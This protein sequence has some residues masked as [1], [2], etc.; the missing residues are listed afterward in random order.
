MINGIGCINNYMNCM[1]TARARPEHAE[2]FN[3]MDTDGSGGIS[4]GELD[5][6]VQQMANQR[7]EGIDTTNAVYTYDADGD[8]ELSQDEMNTFMKETMGPP[9][10]MGGAGPG[11][12][13]N[14]LFN[15]LDTDSSGG[16][17]EK[18]LDAFV[19]DMSSQ[20]GEGI[21]TTTDAFSTYDSDGNGELSQDEL[22]TFMKA[23]GMAPPPP[24]PHGGGGMMTG[25]SSDE[26]SS[27]SSADSIISAYDTNGDGVL[28]ADEL[29]TYLD[30]SGTASVNSLTQQALSAYMMNFENSQ[31]FNTENA[32]LNFAGFNGYSP[33]DL[34]A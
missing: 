18:E 1:Q 24:P 29:Q 9:P 33:V 16:V 14:G 10:H 5:T 31:S 12:D 4:Q 23:S 13:P 25:I 26:E 32:L 34:D 27:S 22:N 2:M 19:Q 7:G 21:D 28:S 15:A 17:S 11:G 20:N 6:F 30:D 3:A 8:G